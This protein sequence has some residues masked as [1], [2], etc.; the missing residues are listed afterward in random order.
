MHRQYLFTKLRTTRKYFLFLI[1]QLVL[2]LG[3]VICALI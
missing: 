2:S 3:V 1:F